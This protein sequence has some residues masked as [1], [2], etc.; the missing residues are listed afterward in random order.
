MGRRESRFDRHWCLKSVCWLLY[1]A[2]MR[3]FV[4]VYVCVRVCVRVCDCVLIHLPH[5]A[6]GSS[7]AADVA[8]ILTYV[9][10]Y[11]VLYMYRRGAD[12]VWLI[13]V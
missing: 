10:I 6:M 11:N 9:R 8:A 7:V 4:C 1:F 5:G 3:A 13:I 2:C 12:I